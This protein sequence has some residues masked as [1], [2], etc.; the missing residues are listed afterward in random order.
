[1]E[2]LSLKTFEKQL[3]N[4]T[5]TDYYMRLKMLATTRFEWEGLPEWMDERWI[6]NFLFDE[7]ECM[8]FIDDLRGPI[9]SLCTQNGK[10]NNY[11]DPTVLAPAGVDM[12]THKTYVVGE[13]CVHIRNNDYSIPTSYFVKLFAYRLSE[14]SRTI[15]INVKAQK[16]PLMVLGPEKQ[17]LTLKNTYAKYE[18][19]EPVIYGDRSLD[20][21]TIKVLKT[22]APIVFPQLHDQKQNYWNECLTFLGINNANTDKRER[23]IT[24]EV[25]ANDVHID[26]SADCFLKARQ[27]AAEQLNKLWGTNIT[28]K[29]RKGGLCECEQ[30]IQSI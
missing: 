2:I 24:G 8:G 25:E 29:M 19:N 6:E 1:M 21:D 20:T 16:T 15:D 28:V 7:G 9:V 4:L 12:P 10:V 30:D 26:L 22:D 27:R 5:F 23:L 3:N 18:G 13:E 11:N 14:I 17:K